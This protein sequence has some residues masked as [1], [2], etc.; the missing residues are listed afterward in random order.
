MTWHALGLFLAKCGIAS[1]L[2]TLALLAVADDPWDGDELFKGPWTG[3]T[4]LIGLDGIK[5]F[6]GKG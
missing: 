5:N 2:G 4:T 6:F 1:I 3:I